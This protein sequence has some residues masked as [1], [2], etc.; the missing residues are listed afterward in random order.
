MKYVNPL[1]VCA[2]YLHRGYTVEFIDTDHWRLDEAKKLKAADPFAFRI[3]DGGLSPG[4]YAKPVCDV[5]I[6]VN[7]EEFHETH[8]EEWLS[9]A[10]QSIEFF[11]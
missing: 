1:D 8:Q 5:C 9:Y 6:S 2:Y 3:T 7:T 10:N 11:I 4:G